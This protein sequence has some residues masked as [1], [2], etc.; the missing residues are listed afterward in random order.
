[1]INNVFKIFLIIF[2]L[3]IIGLGLF[4]YFK[5]PKSYL[6]NPRGTDLGKNLGNILGFSKDTSSDDKPNLFDQTKDS[7]GNN[8]KKNIES[9]KD[10]AYNEAKTT[11]DNVFNKQS[12]NTQQVTVS[13]LGVTNADQNKPIYN[14]D[15][16]KDQDLK[17]NL[18]VNNKYYLKFQNLPQNFCIYINNNKYPINDGLIEIQFAKGGNYP[19]KANKCDL[20]EK[21]IGT[22]TV[23]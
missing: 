6:E 13:V 22:L 9:V 4:F 11:L 18:T 17:L 3:I 16:T 7:I 23:Q 10:L 8:A 15:F 19:I 1:M 20:D 5:V 14:I 2:V 21:N 12:D